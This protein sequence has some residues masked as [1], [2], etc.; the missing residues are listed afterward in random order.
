MLHKRKRKQALG[1][2]GPTAEPGNY[3]L[4]TLQRLGSLHDMFFGKSHV[5]FLFCDAF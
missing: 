1:D 5:I 2:L 3:F 4:S